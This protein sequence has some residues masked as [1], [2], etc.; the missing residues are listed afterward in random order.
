MCIFCNNSNS[1]LLQFHF[2]ET[3]L[4]VF[5]SI[6]FSFNKANN[7]TNLIESSNAILM[8][9]S[10]STFNGNDFGTIIHLSASSVFAIYDQ[11]LFS[12]NNANSIIDFSFNEHYQF[13]I[14][15]GGKL[16]FY[17]NDICTIFKLKQSA[18]PWC[19]FQ[20]FANK[21]SLGIQN[22]SFLVIFCNNHYN[23]HCYNHVPLM[24]CRWLQ[25]SLFANTIPLEINNKFHE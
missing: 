21:V 11:L 17:S 8:I 6:N 2:K 12:F 24:D 25:Y 13:M 23:N 19:I 1:K 4:I 9:A 22:N 16:F 18:Y 7:R 14:L 5:E 20:Y 3:G 15:K 10:N